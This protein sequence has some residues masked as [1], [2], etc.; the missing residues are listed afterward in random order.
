MLTA[1]NDGFEIAKKDLQLRGPGEFF[2]TRQHG[3][4]LLPGLSIDGDV[5]LLDETQKCLRELRNQKERRVEWAIV[6]AQARQDFAHRL[7]QVSL[8]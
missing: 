3:A 7:Q 4:P 5:K 1:T 6:Q 2:G 8:S